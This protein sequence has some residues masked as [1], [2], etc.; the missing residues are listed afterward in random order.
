MSG[1]EI[2]AVIPIKRFEKSK[3]RLAGL[4][5]PEQ[6]QRL[7]EAMLR[8]VLDTIAQTSGLAGALVV[9]ADLEARRIAAEYGAETLNDPNENGP[10]S[11]VGLAARALAA[12]GRSGMLAVMGDVPLVTYEEL[13]R[14]LASHDVGP[15]VTLAPARDGVGCN[16]AVCS[17]VD[18]IG[19][20]F[21]GRSLARHRQMARLANASVTAVELPGLGLD[22]DDA[23]DLTD[24]LARGSRTHAAALCLG[25]ELFQ[26]KGVA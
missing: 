5:N 24:F 3:G 11:A 26:R 8:D 22:I 21:D 15:A 1:P 20:C 23:N 19:L 7:S 25:F 17:P 14:M 12:T 4:L 13:E 16:A 9:S 18:I 10:S 2:T 6:R